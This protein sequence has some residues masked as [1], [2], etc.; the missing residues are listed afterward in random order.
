MISNDKDG[1]G[2]PDYK[3]TKIQDKELTFEYNVNFIKDKSDKTKTKSDT[4]TITLDNNNL[5][6]PDSQEPGQIS[7][8]KKTGGTI[9]QDKEGGFKIE[10]GY[11]LESGKKIIYY[12]QTKGTNNR[13]ELIITNNIQKTILEGYE[14]IY[15]E[16][17]EITDPE[18]ESIRQDFLTNKIERIFIGTLKKSHNTDF[19]NNRK[20]TKQNNNKYNF[21]I[22]F[23]KNDGTQEKIDIPFIK[24]VNSETNT[25]EYVFTTNT[26][27]HY[28]DNIAYD[29]TVPS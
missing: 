7:Q 27:E 22:T 21:E 28:I 9:E 19:Q 6:M 13:A 15:P 18:F 11:T 1:N 20:I 24:T 26:K 23:T 12:T 5:I 17:K 10:N 2:K 16:H 29:I 8:R 14:S 25:N 3:V 4:Y